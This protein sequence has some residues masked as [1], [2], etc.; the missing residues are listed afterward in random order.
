V[1]I[2]APARHALVMYEAEAA[3]RGRTSEWVAA[4]LARGDAVLHRAADA[5]EL[6]DDL[7]ETSRAALDAGSLRLVDPYVCFQQTDGLH[8]ALRQLFEDMVRAAFDDGSPG[9]VLTHG[10]GALQVMAP[11]PAE[12]LA[13]EH[14]LERLTALPGV[15][16]LCCYDLRSEQTDLLEA[17]AGLHHRDVEDVLWSVRL[18][19]D[20]LVVHGEIDADN[21]GRFG[22]ALRVAASHGVGVVD[23]AGVSLLSAAGLRVFEGA[24]DLLHRRGERLRLVGTSPSV[25]RA[26]TAVPIVADGWADLAPAREPEGR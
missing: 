4:A 26:L 9:V 1:D 16:A 7:G 2:R 19:A 17:V 23:L 14:D 18:V 12:R 20:R 22:A 11:E 25:H 6:V 13:F 21:A 24:A 5:A 3:R 8:W 10:A 15:R